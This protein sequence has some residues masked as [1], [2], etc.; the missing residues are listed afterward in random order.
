M[1]GPQL[2]N[3]F[4]PCITLLYTSSYGPT[5]YPAVRR[6]GR[7]MLELGSPVCKPAIAVHAMGPA[8]LP[9]ASWLIAIRQFGEPQQ[10][11]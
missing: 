4:A 9:Q 3:L 8:L 7:L 6:L 11:G 10:R 2:N 1:N 5:T